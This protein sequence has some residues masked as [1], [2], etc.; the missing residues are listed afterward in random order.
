MNPVVW[1]ARAP[2]VQPEFLVLDE[3][4]AGLDEAHRKS[5]A[6]YLKKLTDS[7]QMMVIVSRE[8][9]VPEWIDRVAIFSRGKLEDTLPKHSWDHHPVIAQL[10][11][12]SE[13][14][15]QE[16]VALI[17]S[18]Q[19][20]SRF[21]DPLFQIIDGK[22]AYTVQ[23]IFTAV[24]WPLIMGSIGRLGGRMDPAKVHYST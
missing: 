16:M 23:T 20:S 7:V 4:Y 19:H 5:L 22:V 2:A 14:M 6:E 12:Q 21:A 15:S 10:K 3:P 8:E 13:Q 1:L 17:R 11:A 18:H 9:E 24:N